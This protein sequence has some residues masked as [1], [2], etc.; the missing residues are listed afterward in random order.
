[1]ETSGLT[2]LLFFVLVLFLLLAFFL[3]IFIS[4]RTTPPSQ[5]LAL[6]LKAQNDADQ[7][8]DTMAGQTRCL[9]EGM[10]PC[11]RRE[12]QKRRRAQRRMYQLYHHHAHHGYQVQQVQSRHPR[13]PGGPGNN[14]PG[15]SGPTSVKPSGRCPGDWDEAELNLEEPWK[16]AASH[17]PARS[18]HGYEYGYGTSP[19]S[20]DVEEDSSERLW[21]FIV[22]W[23]LVSCVFGGI[24]LII[25]AYFSVQQDRHHYLHPPDAGWGT[26]DD[27]FWTFETK[28]GDGLME[29]IMARIL[30]IALG[31]KD[32]EDQLMEHGI[33]VFI[34]GINGYVLIRQRIFSRRRHYEMELLQQGAGPDV[35][36]MVSP[37]HTLVTREGPE[38][39]ED[40]EKEDQAEEKHSSQDLQYAS[41]VPMEDGYGGNKHG[42]DLGE[43]RHF[44]GQTTIEG[45]DS[46]NSSVDK[47]TGRPRLGHGRPFKARH[48]KERDDPL[49]H[50]LV[51]AD[52]GEDEDEDGDHEDD[53]PDFRTRSF[54]G[55][56]NYLQIGILIIEFL[57]L[58]SFPL[59]E[60]MEFYN[61]AEKTSAMF[62]SARNIINVFR[63]AA[64]SSSS[65]GTHTDGHVKVSAQGVPEGL[66][67]QDGILAF[68]N[69]TI[70]SFNLGHPSRTEDSNNS[71]LAEDVG[72]VL[73]GGLNATEKNENEVS[74]LDRQ[75]MPFL[76]NAT[77]LAMPWI[78][79]VDG[80]AQWITE[81]LPAWLP[82]ITAL[83][84]STTKTVPAEALAKL[85]ALKHQ[86]VNV[87]ATAAIQRLSVAAAGV[88]HSIQGGA[89][90]NDT[91]NLF[92]Q[93]IG[94]VGDLASAAS[95]PGHGSRLSSAQPL[96]SPLPHDNVGSDGDI[97]MQVVNSLGL[98]PSINT[99]D[100]YLLRF[101]SCF[102]VVIVGWVL[103]LT[104]HGWNRRC[105]RLRRDG[106]AH[107]PS[108]SIGWASC[109]I[110]VV[111]QAIH[112]Y[113]HERHLREQEQARL[114]SDLPIQAS[115][116][117]SSIVSTLLD[118]AS[119]V[120]HPASSL[121]CTGPNVQ[122]SLYLAASLLAYTLA[123]L[124]FM[125]FLTSFERPPVPGEICFRPNGVVV[126]KNLGLLLAV[127]FLLIQSPSQR[128]FRGLVSIGIMLAMACYTIRRRPCYWNKINYWRTF[129]FSCVLYASLLVALLCPAPTPSSSFS[130]SARGAPTS[131]T[132]PSSPSSSSSS[133]TGGVWGFL[134]GTKIEGRWVMAPRLKMSQNAW[135]IAGGPKVMLACIA[136]G[137]AIL[138][139]VF[140]VVD[141]VFL[142]RWSRRSVLRKYAMA[143]QFSNVAASVT[144]SAMTAAV[145][146][147]ASIAT[148]TTV[149]PM[150]TTATSAA[151][152][153]DYAPLGRMRGYA[154]PSP[155]SASQQQPMYYSRG[156]QDVSGGGGGVQMTAMD[157]QDCTPRGPPPPS[158]SSS[159]SGTAPG[160]RRDGGR[161]NESPGK[162]GS[163]W[164][165]VDL[166]KENDS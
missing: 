146:T 100:W 42:F 142:R 130:S 11:R 59:R 33:F 1:M 29:V 17:Y 164:S 118:P 166:S 112:A 139:I 25:G 95:D 22:G 69:S 147:S 106:K 128:R 91:A 105:R 37:P 68:G 18:L 60:L 73:T 132:A 88:G 108:L 67:Y 14:V 13:P 28:K 26:G 126:L 141:R 162:T 71:I 77:A 79:N 149:G 30:N 3:Y 89:F 160:V 2:I 32:F 35:T 98:Q 115:G 96:P 61:Q 158:L 24:A 49:G 23:C 94:L 110:P 78:K 40:N 63:T 20:G 53:S 144:A 48:E 93:G 85:E 76:A 80:S 54:M 151:H 114:A 101:W 165:V 72:S 47:G 8:A 45:S 124:L 75:T 134:R 15:S 152:W 135:T 12:T 111:S 6:W 138:V 70:F 82:N 87:A 156:G 163:Y 148:A 102:L 36:A 7:L 103:A 109:F 99:H 65:S 5:R 133:P 56:F 150:A 125:V 119:T 155:D 4:H 83:V 140:V 92:R 66:H 161:A 16:R 127:D 121:L 120:S 116:I 57:Q 44:R 38:Q 51:R 43:T 157:P 81:H 117:L 64:L 21:E 136:A 10:R 137:W 31:I 46:D 90:Q 55:W 27:W 107:W 97:V 123:Y 131:S 84:S 62:E 41:V 153:T 9:I 50:A 39:V 74:W 154:Q 113:A 122:P 104:V 159:F 129:S 19:G 86:I 34:A 58:F 145:A 52:M 143:Q